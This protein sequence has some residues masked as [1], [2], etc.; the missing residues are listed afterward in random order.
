MERMPSGGDVTSELVDV[1]GGSKTAIF[2][3]LPF[4]STAKSPT[5]RPVTGWPCLSVTTTSTTT[6]RVFARIVIVGTGVLLTESVP[7]ANLRIRHATRT[8]RNGRPRHTEEPS[9]LQERVSL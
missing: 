3:C 7:E 9:L 4:S 8:P 1:R 6:R 2:C 5:F